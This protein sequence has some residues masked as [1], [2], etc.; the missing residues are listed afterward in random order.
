MDSCI[1][2]VSLSIDD[3]L[4]SVDSELERYKYENHDLNRRLS[5]LDEYCQSSKANT[6]NFLEKLN[7][8]IKN[9]YDPFLCMCHEL[10]VEG[11]PS[12][13][14]CVYCIVNKQIKGKF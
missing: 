13:Y 12:E 11:Y 2:E 3:R 10:K 5:E 6:Q 4:C 8:D 7:H 1:L 14:K 9:D